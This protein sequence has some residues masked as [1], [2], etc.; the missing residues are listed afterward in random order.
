MTMT[1]SWATKNIKV[2]SGLVSNSLTGTEFDIANVQDLIQNSVFDFMEFADKD[3]MDHNITGGVSDARDRQY[4]LD[5]KAG[6]TGM[7][8]IYNSRA[9]HE[10]LLMFYSPVYYEDEFV[11]SLVGVYQAS[12][13]ITGFLTE[14]YFGENADSYLIE[15]DGRVIAATSGYNPQAKTYISDIAGHDDAVMRQISAAMASGKPTT[16]SFAGNDVGGVIA[17]LPQTGYYM[18]RIFPQAAHE[19]VVAK[20]NKLVFLVVVMMIAVF[21]VLVACLNHFYHK[22]QRVVEAA[23]KEAED[24]NAAKT[25]FLFNMSHD[26]RTPMNAIIGFRTLL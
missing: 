24:A 5:A 11:G 6:N 1:L 26:I 16:I 7:E 8:L 18:L 19:G 2:L 21:A 25:T 10:T 20:S 23:R 3:G 13:R 17:K 9:T 12:N 14:R 4:Y 22:E 15:A